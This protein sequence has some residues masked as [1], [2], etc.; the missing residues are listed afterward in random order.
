MAERSGSVDRRIVESILA[1][2]ADRRLLQRHGFKNQ[3][4]ADEGLHELVDYRMIYGN[5]GAGSQH[6]EV[7]YGSKL[8]GEVPAT[9][10]LRVKAGALV[11]FA[12]KRWR[13]QKA[14]PEFILLQPSQTSGH[15]I[16][17]TYP[18]GGVGFDAFLIDRM[19]HILH[20]ENYPLGCLCPKSAEPCGQ[21]TKRRAEYMPSGPDPICANDQG[22][23]LFHFCRLP[24]EQGCGSHFETDR[25]NIG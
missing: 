3:Y 1:E 24:R 4:G 13:V 10:L 12:G 2:L 22:D 25:N 5:F 7:R 15:A 6:I 19:W 20:S 9:N 21:D 14:S 17:F 18:G 16:D 8:L 23:S 11:Q